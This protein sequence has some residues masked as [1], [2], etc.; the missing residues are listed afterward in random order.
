MRSWRLTKRKLTCALFKHPAGFTQSSPTTHRIL[1]NGIRD[2]SPLSLVRVERWK[3]TNNPSTPVNSTRVTDAASWK[4]LVEFHQRGTKAES[5][6]LNCQRFS[7]MAVQ[8]VRWTS[9]LFSYY[10]CNQLPFRRPTMG[11]ARA[12]LTAG[13]RTSAC[14]FLASSDPVYANG[15]RD[16]L[17]IFHRG[18][19]RRDCFALRT[20]FQLLAHSYQLLYIELSVSTE[21]SQTNTM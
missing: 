20:T 4:T 21:F 15:K 7:I 1:H 12:I 9:L 2:V 13:W 10:R 3:A 8:Q 14:V 18:A 17:R 6:W 16:F 11:P 19:F 5:R